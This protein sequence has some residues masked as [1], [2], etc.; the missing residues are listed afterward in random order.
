MKDRGQFLYPS[1]QCQRKDLQIISG[2]GASVLEHALCHRILQTF[3]DHSIFVKE[4]SSSSFHFPISITSIGNVPSLRYS[5]F[6]Q[7]VM[8]HNLG[9]YF[10]N[11]PLPGR[12]S[13]LHLQHWQLQ[14]HILPFLPLEDP[15][16]ADFEADIMA[17][18]RYHLSDMYTC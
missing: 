7:P 9:Q 14:Q 18:L 11:S 12:V 6:H 3:L 8:I 4:P 5:Y 13:P 2:L 1:N 10:C 16:L 15:N 17:T